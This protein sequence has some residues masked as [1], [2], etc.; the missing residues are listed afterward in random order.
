[1]NMMKRRS[2][3]SNITAQ[4]PNM[5]SMSEDKGVAMNDEQL[6]IT[7]TVKTQPT[8][9]KSAHGIATIN[10]LATAISREK[11]P[12]DPQTRSD[13]CFNNLLSFLPH[14]EY[15][16][17]GVY[18]ALDVPSKTL[19]KWASKGKKKLGQNVVARLKL[20]RNTAPSEYRFAMDHLYV[21]GLENGQDVWAMAGQEYDRKL[22]GER[23]GLPEK[24]Q[25]AKETVVPSSVANGASSS[26]SMKASESSKEQGQKAVVNTTTAASEKKAD[27]SEMS[28]R[29]KRNPKATGSSRTRTSG[30][31]KAL[32]EFSSE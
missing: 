4:S 17:L 2:Y 6:S 30:I 16:L 12:T 21:W 15:K 24:T 11:P 32:G 26:Q 23:W 20:Q 9:S 29:P 7:Q 3:Q 25:A 27:M 8:S 19:R 1:M 22:K 18:R 13:F 14:D 31:K 28:R 5:A 10:V